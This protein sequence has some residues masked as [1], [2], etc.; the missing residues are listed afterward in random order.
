MSH[1]G[2]LR[3]GWGLGEGKGCKGSPERADGRWTGELSIGVTLNTRAWPEHRAP[4]LG[5]HR[6]K[7]HRSHGEIPV[8]AL[9]IRQKVC[10]IAVMLFFLNFFIEI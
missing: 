2:E 6:R 5:N 4:V 7:F 8:H 10:S 9:K 1:R 3:D